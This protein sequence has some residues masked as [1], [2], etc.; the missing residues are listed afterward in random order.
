MNK[1]YL[2]WVAF[3]SEFAEKLLPYMEDR[4]TLIEKIKAVYAAIDMRLP[5]LEKDNN[6]VDIDPF[7]IFG[8]FNKGIT[9]ANRIAILKGISQE[10]SVKAPVPTS[11]NG[12]PVL[13]N[14]KATYYSF[15]SDRKDDDIAQLCA[16][17]PVKIS[18]IAQAVDQRLAARNDVTDHQ[19]AVRHHGQLTVFDLQSCDLLIC[20]DALT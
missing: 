3:Y 7:T 11:F 19:C 17:F 8:L 16:V 4:K 18:H 5:K 6:I 13:N 15:I 2:T 12:I 10:F 1:E 9:D 14:Q 20:E